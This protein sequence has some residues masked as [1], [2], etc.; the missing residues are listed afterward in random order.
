MK[1]L[2][3]PNCIA[4]ATI[5]ATATLLSTAQPSG[6]FFSVPSEVGAMSAQTQ[7]DLTGI[8]QQN[9]EKFQ[10]MSESDAESYYNQLLLTYDSNMAVADQYGDNS[11]SNQAKS[12]LI[13]LRPK[14][15]K[16]TYYYNGKGQRNE[17]YRFATAYVDATIH[18]SMRELNPDKDP[19]IYPPIV[20]MAATASSN[21][22]D[23]NR[24]IAYLQE[25]IDTKHPDK[26]ET[27]FYYLAQNC[28]GAK[29]YSRCIQVVDEASQ[30]FPNNFNLLSLGVAASVNGNELSRLPNLLERA[31]RL[32]PT[33]QSLLMIQGQLA[34][35]AGDFAKAADVFNKLDQLK[36]NNLSINKHL[37]ICNY[38]LGVR[39]YN[40]A[41]VNGN[42]KEAQNAKRS[43]INFF[44]DAAQRLEL[45]LQS[46]P[47]DVR[48]LTSLGVCYTCMGDDGNLSQVNSRLQAVG[49][50]PIEKV[51]I[52]P[53]MTYNSDGS[54]NIDKEKKASTSSQSVPSFQE[55]ASDYVTSRLKEWSERGKFEKSEQYAERVNQNSIKLKHTELSFQAEEEY[56]SK[57]GMECLKNLTLKGYDADNETYLITTNYGEIL[58]HVPVKNQEAE[59]FQATWGQVSLRKPRII[60]HED[61]P[62]I[63]SVTFE[64]PNGKK[65]EYNANEALTYTQTEV[66][67]DFDKLLGNVAQTPVARS[68]KNVV[69][70]N[71]IN[72]GKTQTITRKSD[73]DINIPTTKKQNTN[74]LALIIANENYKNVSPVESAL[75]DGE[76]MAQY[77]EQTLGIPKTNILQYNDASLADIYRGIS[78]LRGIADA[79]GENTNIIVYYAGHGMPDEAT[80]DA[81]LLPA[82]GDAQL[83]PTCYSL[84]KFY[85]DLAE[86]KSANTFV[87]MDACFSGSQRGE[88]MLMAARGVK[89]RP[90]ETALAGNMFVLSAATGQETAMPYTDKNHGLFTY[91][92]LKKLQDSKGKC[93]LKELSDY[94]IGEVRLQSNLVNHKSQTP[95]MTVSGTLTSKLNDTKLI[96]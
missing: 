21:S 67:I 10:G 35:D 63:G 34:E 29:N 45:I 64:T 65:Y 59:L 20:Y 41:I 49:Q 15:L 33:D 7:A 47:S 40:D 77:C 84:N 54:G 66:K 28:L 60:I 31:L 32:K 3:Y 4:V 22:K 80:K 25:Y 53:L 58:L 38:N 30:L 16:A 89:I 18:P 48:M 61:H 68:E 70:Q 56:K 57:Y 75:H 24:A 94:V 12:V 27:A 81:Y 26:R 13:L 76:V 95:T 2:K 39:L 8:A 62:I 71:T 83:P 6:L 1:S 36:P 23:Y 90:K 74:T 52:P 88:G 92:L 11:I 91:Y 78:T 72:S 14:L 79:M 85:K 93:S 9:Y 73:V 50:T 37:A 51:S 82:D 96:P 5:V 17:M 43:S 55:F 44:K 46:D 86:I 42:T 87:F 19:S 69:A